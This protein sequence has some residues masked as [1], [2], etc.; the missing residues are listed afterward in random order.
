[1]TEIIFIKR[2]GHQGE[3]GLFVDTPIFEEEWQS[4]KFGA[5]VKADCVMPANLKYLKFYWAMCGKV[6]DNCDWLIDKREASDRILL[7]AR[8]FKTVF[9]PLR[10]RAE[11]KPKSVAGLSGDTWIRLLRRCTHV[12]ITKF[13]PGMEEN[14]LKAEI[15]KMIGMDVFAPAPKS[16]PKGGD[17]EKP[18]ES[19]PHSTDAPVATSD[20]SSK[21]KLI[22]E[23]EADYLRLCRSWIEKQTDRNA[24]LDYYDSADQVSLRAKVRLSVGN[25]KS[26]RTELLMHFEKEKT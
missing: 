8:H 4:L 3:V 16:Q 12:V 11:V 22:I 9:D 25:N 23:T 24:A 19:L 15:E 1:V 7:E 18:P 2:A 20:P 13:L 17:G 26:L 21:P 10:N 6:A 5:E 14:V